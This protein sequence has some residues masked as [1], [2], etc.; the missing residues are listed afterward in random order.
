MKKVVHVGLS[1]IAVVLLISVI[2]RPGILD[3]AVLLEKKHPGYW[4][5]LRPEAAATIMVPDC[6]QDNYLISSLTTGHYNGFDVVV[7]KDGSVTVDG[8]NNDEDVHIRYGRI[9]LQDG[10]YTLSDGGAS[11]KLPAGYS[12]VY[13]SGETLVA[14]PDSRSFVSDKSLHKNY[15]IGI[16]LFKGCIADNV[17]FYPMLNKGDKAEEYAP[18]AVNDNKEVDDNINTDLKRAAIIR[19]DYKAYHTI[20]KGDID[21][22]NRNYEH[23]FDTDWVSIM[24]EDGMGIQ[25]VDGEE[26]Y[27]SMDA[28]GRV[29]KS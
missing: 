24:F 22:F 23:L 4:E 5:Y 25:F 20:P 28:W 16:V 6:E 14:L 15:E 29:T 27:G 1:V 10:V 7:N 19:M 12:Y 13:D 8:V 18:Y 26:R 11:E 9:S 21:H 3:S 2:V 17:T